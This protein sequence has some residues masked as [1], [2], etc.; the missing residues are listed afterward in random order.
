MATDRMWNY[1]NKPMGYLDN[2]NQFIPYTVADILLDDFCVNVDAARVQWH[3]STDGQSIMQEVMEQELETACTT[4]DYSTLKN[5]K[6]H[7]VEYH[8]NGYFCWWVAI[9]ITPDEVEVLEKE[10]YDYNY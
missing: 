4:G 5:W 8:S 3:N 2:K 9:S 10:Y 7:G 6:V 1:G